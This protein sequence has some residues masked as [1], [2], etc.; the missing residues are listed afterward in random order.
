M[1]LHSICTEQRGTLWRLST[2]DANRRRKQALRTTSSWDA[3]R[4]KTVMAFSDCD[5][6][7]RK[8]C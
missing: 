7:G 1:T 8:K 5:H 6:R 4:S 3:L 2:T